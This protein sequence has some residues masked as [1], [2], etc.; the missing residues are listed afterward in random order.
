MLRPIALWVC[1]S[2]LAL[3]AV[4]LLCW[5][6][7]LTW[8][9]FLGK[10]MPD[11]VFVTLMAPLSAVWPVDPARSAEYGL[12]CLGVTLIGVAIGYSTGPK[13]LMAIIGRT[14]AT[15]LVLSMIAVVAFPDTGV[16]PGAWRGLFARGQDIAA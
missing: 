6:H 5:R 4:S 14:L 10:R 1:W 12:S 11:L 3:A 8:L 2:V 15:M 9:A 16:H 13:S 7:R